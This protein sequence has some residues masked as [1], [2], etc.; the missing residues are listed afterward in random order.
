VTATSLPTNLKIKYAFR[1][2]LLYT[3]LIVGV[4]LVTFPFLWM[5]LTSFKTYGEAISVPPTMIPSAWSNRVSVLAHMFGR[6]PGILAALVA[7]IALGVYA[8]LRTRNR[9]ARVGYAVV[10]LA[11]F[12]LAW[13]LGLFGQAARFDILWDQVALDLG[14]ELQPFWINY[15]D[16]WNRA[17]FLAYF[18]NSLIMSVVTPLLVVATGAPA[19]YAFARIDFPGKNVVFMLF[20]ATMMIPQEVILIPNFITVSKLGWIDTYPALIVPWIVNVVTIFFLRQFFMSIPDDLYD[21]A[22]LD[23]AG[24]FQFLRKVA[25]PLSVPALVST[26]LFNFLGSWNSVQWPLYVTNSPTMRPLM[27]GMRYF[28]NE[29]GMSVHLHNAAATFT[30]IPVIILFLLVQRQFIE[31]IARTGIK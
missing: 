25:L 16:A 22:V 24:H 8:A 13:R 17:P 12:G 14:Y 30:T 4:V 5:I 10:H 26:S 2:A 31:G 21:A 29:A 19:A 20:L 28:S 3:I 23:G 11:F 7:W 1:R 9:W 15:I 6:S 18:K 27:V